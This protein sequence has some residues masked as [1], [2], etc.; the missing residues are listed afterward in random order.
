MVIFLFLIRIR[1]RLL[2]IEA[3]EVRCKIIFYER[4]K[5][6]SLIF[7]TLELVLTNQKEVIDE[8]SSNIH[9]LKVGVV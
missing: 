1:F 2:K 9:Q 4:S 7:L 8:M 6:K 3:D 5:I